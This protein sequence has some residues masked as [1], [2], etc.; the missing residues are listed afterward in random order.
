VALTCA[1]EERGS[2]PRSTTLDNGSEFTGIALE[3]WAIQHG[4]QLCFIRP[5]RP[6]ENGFTD[7]FN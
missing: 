6:A 1:I 5:S 2:A 3:A 4:I 7:S